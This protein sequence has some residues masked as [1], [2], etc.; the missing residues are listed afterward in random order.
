MKR[1]KLYSLLSVSVLSVVVLFIFQIIDLAIIFSIIIVLYEFIIGN[2]LI[3]LNCSFNLFRYSIPYLF[4]FFI[5]CLFNVRYI[6]YI[7]LKFFGLDLQQYK[8]KS[9]VT[10]LVFFFKE[11]NYGILF[12]V[13]SLFMLVFLYNIMYKKFLIC[14][15]I[16]SFYIFI[17]LSIYIKRLLIKN[18]YYN[19]K[20]FNIC[21]N[22][23]LASIFSLYLIE[24]GNTLEQYLGFKINLGEFLYGFFKQ[25]DKI[26]FKLRHDNI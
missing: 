8:Y 20:T 3:I 11:Y 1:Q 13:N 18:N 15:L 5:L 2:V 24:S 21:I 22:V 10:S 23:I 25:K 12:V 9:K 7:K 19:K 6:S 17:G 26:L 4:I 14:G 16:I